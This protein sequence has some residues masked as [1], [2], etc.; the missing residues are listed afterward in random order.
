MKN[1]CP[2]PFGH[3]TVETKGGYWPCCHHAPPADQICN[4]RDV[5]HDQWFSGKYMSDLRQSFLDDEKHT[6]CQVCWNSEDKGQQSLRQRVLKEYKILKTDTRP[7]LVNVEVQLGNL[8]NLTCL[9]CDENSSSAILAENRRLGINLYQQ[10]DFAWTESAWQNLEAMIGSGLK[11]LNIRGGEPFYNKGLIDIIERMSDER[12]SNLVLHVTTNATIWSERW[13][14]ALKR[15]R[16]VRMMFSVDAVGDLYEYIRYPASWQQVS[17]NID[18]I[19]TCDNINP[20]VHAVAQNLNIHAIGELIDWCEA[21]NMFLEIDQ[22]SKPEHLNL[23]NLPPELNKRAQ[24]HLESYLARTDKPHLLQSLASYL[25]Q[26][27]STNYDAGAWQSFLSQI[28]ARD[29][30][31]GNDFSKFLSTKDAV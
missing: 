12:C 8:C 15:F 28:A 27:R 2:L 23:T 26:L 3:I 19:R 29:R 4:I 22:L 31:R 11:V 24:K 20:M 25:E 1:Y 10:K 30:L 5:T 14:Q 21:R 13:Q 16:L 9:M 18:Q 17:D 7:A 6:G